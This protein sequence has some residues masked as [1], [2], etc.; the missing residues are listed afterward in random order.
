MT[1]CNT[2]KRKFH[3]LVL[4]SSPFLL[5]GFQHHSHA[6]T[7]DSHDK[8][9]VPGHLQALGQDACHCVR[10]IAQADPT[11]GRRPFDLL[12]GRPATAAVPALCRGG[13]QDSPQTHQ[14][15]GEAAAQCSCC[16]YG[17]PFFL[18][19]ASLIIMYIV[20]V[21]GLLFNRPWWRL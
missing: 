11:H 8:A 18:P 13:P 20:Y 4:F 10:P 6:V 9:S 2:Y 14:R 16:L 19:S 12:R 3:W 7:T 17:L 5:S 1:M 21:P 15:Q